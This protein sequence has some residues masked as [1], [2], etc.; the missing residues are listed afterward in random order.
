M[1]PLLFGVFARALPLTMFGPLLPGIASSLGA[2]L[3]DVGWIVAT[4]ATGSLIAQPLMGTLSDAYGRRRVFTWCMVLFV[5]GSTVCAAATSLPVLVAGRVLQ[6]LGAGGIQP[7]ATAII[8]DVLPPE[9]RGSALGALYG[10]FGIGTMAG[11]LLGGAIVAA[12]LAQAGHVGGA[13]GADLRAYPWHPVFAVN[14]AFGIATIVLARSLPDDARSAIR[15]RATSFDAVGA[16]LIA[17]FAACLM[18][19]VTGGRM[20]SLLGG[21][22]ALASI[23]IFIRHI[24]HAKSPLIDPALFA[25]R[26]PALLYSIAILFGIPSFSLTIYSATYYIAQFHASAASAGLALFV[27]AVLYV[28][29]AIAGGALINRFGTRPL[30]AT[31]AALVAVACGLLAGLTS[32]EAVTSAMALGGLGLGLASAPPN[33]LILRYVPSIRAGAATGVA[34]MLGTSGSITAPAVIGAF[35]AGARSADAA[36]SLRAE[37][38]LCAALAAI[39]ALLTSALPKPVALA[40]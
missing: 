25:A 23:G 13:L 28:A 11:A 4:Y 2:S 37:F 16:L 35:L 29:G 8:G 27:L 9:R 31:G 21:L 38:A 34:T 20:Q 5:A 12:A 19:A 24:R 17:V 32:V 1:R 40:V 3:A 7:I 15:A 18:F 30:L 6:A 26:G 10:V 36:S 39:C 33:A 22:A 14:I